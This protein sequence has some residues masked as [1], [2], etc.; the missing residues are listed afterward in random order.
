[1]WVAVSSGVRQVLPC[2]MA[3]SRWRDFFNSESI[4]CMVVSTTPP[5]FA[6][7]GAWVTMMPSSVATS[8]STSSTPTVYFATMR[9]CSDASRTP[10]SMRPPLMEVPTSASASTAIAAI[11]SVVFAGRVGPRRLAERD[12]AAG[13]LESHVALLVSGCKD[14]DPGCG[15][16]SLH[17]I[18]WRCAMMRYRVS[19]CKAGGASF[20]HA[21][22]TLT[23]SPSP[24]G[25]EEQAMP[26][27]F[28]DSAALRSK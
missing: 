17:C 22:P 12:V 20:P 10:R 11:S 19:R 6:S 21:P 26:E 14:D 25:R 28:L 9:S 5:Q 15:H 7:V 27:R 2:F 16:D 4:C 18:K 13:L 1:M 3:A 24:G 23:P 8:V